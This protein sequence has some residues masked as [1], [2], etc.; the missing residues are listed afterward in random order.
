M[1]FSL[2]KFCLGLS[3]GFFSGVDEDCVLEYC[4]RLLLTLLL[5]LLFWWRVGIGCDERNSLE[6]G[7]GGKSETQNI[8]KR[9]KFHKYDGNKYD[10]CKF[11]MISQEVMR[12][13][14]WGCMHTRWPST[15]LYRNFYLFVILWIN[16]LTLKQETHYNTINRTDS[17]WRLVKKWCSSDR[18]CDYMSEI[19]IIP[20]I[21]S[22]IIILNCSC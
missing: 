4:T 20:I 13:M 7:S 2:I 5:L 19:D 21:P 15:Y 8:W 11:K 10:Y 22:R 12:T 9:Y 18:F 14:I 16:I 3:S 6:A 17:S 1:A